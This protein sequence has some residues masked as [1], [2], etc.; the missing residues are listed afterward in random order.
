MLFTSFG[1]DQLVVKDKEFVPFLTMFRLYLPIKIVF[2]QPSD[3]LHHDD[4]F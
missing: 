1:T 2:P 4:F 3:A